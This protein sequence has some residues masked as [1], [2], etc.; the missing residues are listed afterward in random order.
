MIEIS[1]HARKA[2][3]DDDLTEDE[4]KQCLEH[5]ELEIKQLVKG[6]MRYGKKLEL[7]NKTIMVVFTHRNDIQRVITCYLIKRKRKW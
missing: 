1:D 7:K 6:E 3:E 4:I 5:G 2:M